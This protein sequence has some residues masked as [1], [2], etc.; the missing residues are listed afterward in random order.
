MCL[1]LAQANSHDHA[2]SPPPL[3]TTVYPAVDWIRG[4]PTHP[5]VDGL[6]DP[7]PSLPSPSLP[8]SLPSSTLSAS[9]SFADTPLIPVLP[10]AVPHAS[11]CLLDLHRTLKHTTPS[12]MNRQ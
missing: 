10:Q 9:L 7:S 11:P 3:S 8:S 4:L 6:K 2:N 5:S 1:S 12:R